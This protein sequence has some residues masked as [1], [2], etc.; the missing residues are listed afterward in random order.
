M[1]KQLGLELDNLARKL[2]D[3]GGLVA[4]VGRAVDLA[5]G[6]RF[7]PDQMRQ[8]NR[9]NQGSF[10]V[11]PGNLED[12]AAHHATSATIWLVDV[13]NELLLPFRELERLALPLA[14][15]DRHMLDEGNDALGAQLALG[16]APNRQ[17]GARRTS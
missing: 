8:R 11:L 5:V 9:S 3:D 4:I 6:F 15:R 1:L 2:V 12:R 7:R 13:A 10:A 14:A 17:R 16:R